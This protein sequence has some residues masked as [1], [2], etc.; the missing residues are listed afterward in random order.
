MFCDESASVIEKANKTNPSA[1]S[2]TKTRTEKSSVSSMSPAPSM[3]ATVSLKPNKTFDID[4]DFIGD[5]FSSCAGFGGDGNAFDGM[6]MAVQADMKYLTHHCELAHFQRSFK[7][8][9]SLN[10]LTIIR[11]NGPTSNTCTS[12]TR[13]SRHTLAS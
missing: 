13:S 6:A 3:R 4:S 11:Y 10:L 8:A 12:R 9:T 1:L 2:K 7:A 5:A